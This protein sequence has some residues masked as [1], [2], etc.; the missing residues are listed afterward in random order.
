MFVEILKEL[1]RKN[2][3]TQMQLAEAIGVSAGNVGDWENGKSKPSYNA[4]IQ[5]SKF[6]GVSADVLLEIESPSAHV[7][8]L[9]RTENELLLMLRDMDRRDR[10]D[11]MGLVLL[12]YNRY[13][14]SKDNLQLNNQESDL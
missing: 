7:S 13:T 3:V 4:L 1:R 12:K 9:S 5:I 6:F 14:R 2:D 8:N 11:I 10:E